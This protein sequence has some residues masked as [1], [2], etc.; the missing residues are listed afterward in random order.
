[1]SPEGSAWSEPDRLNALISNLTNIAGIECSMKDYRAALT[2]I[3][4]AKAL[5][6]YLPPSKTS[7]LQRLSV[8]EVQSD[9]LA[10]LR[11]FPPAIELALECVALSKELSLPEREASAHISLGH[12]H[13]F[14]SSPP[15]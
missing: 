8:V 2:T 7:S 15:P 6:S 11:T 1:M 5:L 14:S 12:M 10:G 4:R 3:S 9:C 13:R